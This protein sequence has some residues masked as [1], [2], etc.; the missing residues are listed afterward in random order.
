[1]ASDDEQ[2][3]MPSAAAFYGAPLNSQP[4]RGGSLP[5]GWNQS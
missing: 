5:M 4:D 3:Q 1:M 2:G